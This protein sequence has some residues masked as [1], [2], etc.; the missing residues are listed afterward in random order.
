MA[1]QVHPLYPVGLLDVSKYQWGIDVEKAKDAGVQALIIRAGYGIVEDI[2][3]REHRVT[4]EKAGWPWGAYWYWRPHYSASDQARKM[5]S[6]VGTNPPMGVYPDF[7][8]N[9]RIERWPANYTKPFISRKIWE[10]LEACDQTFFR[11]AGIYT[12]PGFWNNWVVPTWLTKMQINTRV[13]WVANWYYEFAKQPRNP[14]GWFNWDLWQFSAE[15]GPWAKKARYFGVTG[16]DDVDV[17]VFNGTWQDFMTKFNLP[18]SY[19]G[20][21]DG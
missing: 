4:A 1:N 2:R 21:V 12:S 6:V 14:R 10:M 17:D 11:K 9:P 20:G 18:A 15:V 16:D 13:R 19:A 7:E 5:R 3:F 8:Y